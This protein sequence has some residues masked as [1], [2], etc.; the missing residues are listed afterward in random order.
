MTRVEPGL[1]SGPSLATAVEAP[2]WKPLGVVLVG[3]FLIV[4]D[5]FIVNVALPSIQRGLGASPAELEWVVAGY[6]LAFAVLLVTGGRIGDLVGRRL[7]F[8]VGVSVFVA[9][10][11]ACG[12]APTPASL[13]A[14]RLAQGVGAALISPN[15]LSVIGVVYPGPHRVR[16]VTAYGLVMGLA[17]VFGQVIG[18]LLIQANVAG[19]AWRPI[20]LINLPIGIA[21][22]VLAPR[23][24]P[25]SKGSDGRVDVVGV[26]LVTAGLAALVLPPVQGRQLGWP[27]WT[28]LSLACAPVVFA[29][30]AR[31]QKARVGHGR[32][33]LLHPLA[34]K[35]ARLRAG[36]G[37]QLV[38][39][40]TQAA[41][42]L[43]LALYLQDG[44]HLSPIEAG[45]VFMA[46]AGAYL[47]VSLR[48]P[49]LTRRYGRKLIAAGTL[50]A[51][52]GDLALLA[53]VVEQSGHVAALLPGLVL[54]GAGQGLWITPLTATVLSFAEPQRAGLVSG[55]LSTMQQV[56]N[57][58]GVAVAGA[59]FFATLHDGYDHAFSY[60]L[61][62][63][64]GVLCLAALLTPLLRE[65]PDPSR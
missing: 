6:G 23:I 65:R 5:F 25:E 59:V 20:F 32:E 13:I 9:A 56:G 40:S 29:G 10:S 58:L 44:R 8:C 45:L 27:L 21:A 31:H 61:V 64:A 55:A 30:L 37:V 39:W 49:S 41:L 22:L 48:A 3:T 53:A 35:D 1:E 51:A 60:V 62:E 52:A 38:C 34:F 17:A 33:P 57:A 50:T 26:L 4:L 36:L 19:S 24:V 7:V 15:V 54:V 14:A 42:F 43:V 18:G 47:V 63:L 46:L 16:A 11:A 28:W 12:L 2:S